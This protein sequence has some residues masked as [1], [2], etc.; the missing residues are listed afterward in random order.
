MAKMASPT[1]CLRGANQYGVTRLFSS[2]PVVGQGGRI[3]KKQKPTEKEPIVT[4]VKKAEVPDKA[5]F[6][7]CWLSDKFPRCDGSHKKHNEATGDNV[8]PM[9]VQA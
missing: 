6:C 2:S 7:R 9:V 8:G 5:A 3:N 4:A 1:W